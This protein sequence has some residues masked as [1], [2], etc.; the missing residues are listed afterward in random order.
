M[1]FLPS[2]VRGFL[3][4]AKTYIP[5]QWVSLTG[6]G[7]STERNLLA[8]NKEWVFI[9]TDKIATAL[10]GVR[11]KVMRYSRSSDDQ[12]VFDGALVD[13]LETPAENI[14]GKDFLYLNT[15]NKEL[16]GN[17]FWELLPGNKLRPL[18]ATAVAP[19]LEN[20]KLTGYRYSADGK[21][22]VILPED[23]IHDRYIDPARP[24]WGVGKLAKIA[25]WVDTSSFANEFLRRF[26]VNGATFGGFI[27]TEEES[28]ERIK[29][30]KAGLVN[31]HTG[32][33]N[34]HKIAVLP[35]GSKF[36]KV[37]ANMAEME[38]GETDDRYRDK[39]L[40]AFG[41]PKSILGLVT[42]VNR[43]NAEAMEYVF[44]KYTVKP[45]ADDLIDFLNTKIA[46]LLDPSGKLYF[47]YDEFVP[48][49]QEILLKEREIALNKQPYMTVN[50][51]RAT[52]GL[53][54][55]KGGEVIYGNPMLLPLG[56]PA[57]SPDGDPGGDDDEEPK[58]AMPARARRA[59]RKERMIDGLAAKVAE[60]ASRIDP[61]ELAFKKFV[62]RV[63]DYQAQLAEK[64]RDFNGRQERDVLTNLNQITKAVSKGD[65]FDMEGQVSLLIDF[66]TPL[67]K[68]LMIEQAVEEYLAQEF[69]G[70]LDTGHS[71]FS[72]AV[73]LAAK[74]LAK[75]Y[76]NTTAKLLKSALNDGLTAGEDFS[77]LA[78][79]V[80]RVYEYSN[81]VRARMVA[82]NEAFYIA[83]K[84][85]L[86][87][88]RQSGVVK[89]IR[90]YT[91]ED[92]RVCEFCGP[93]HGKVIGVNETFYAKGQ[94][95]T[96]RDGGKLDLT[97]RTI[98]V[99]PLHVDCR[100]FIRAEQIEIT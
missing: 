45:I 82:H 60:I 43:A 24:Y 44:A 74:R 55:V 98:D 28:E 81:V 90:W 27:E 56:T 6:P 88:Y 23:V 73:E 5:A 36:A 76:N 9:A 14:T 37:T 11:F 100:C 10:V 4:K 31:D 87:A 95:L 89:T 46:P 84:G 97:Y 63:D 16:T 85:S 72:K 25:R 80:Q 93:E 8:A 7:D 47:A 38:M 92:E 79:R 21:V 35:K 61:D 78:A 34:A 51:V 2:F 12:E 59:D 49:N 40:A 94:T 83:N 48:V 1:N 65:L 18:I 20:G 42:D 64:V 67:L 70:T 68:G 19:I 30:I 91:A 33:D 62:G 75:S 3:F 71:A 15:A 86:E 53:P 17:S 96:G 77:Q 32:V 99:P 57:A 66:V 22:R 13:F 58:K 29:L 52:V 54:P 41:V 69:P 50:E 26:F 39:I